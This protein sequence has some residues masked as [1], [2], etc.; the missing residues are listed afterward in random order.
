[1]TDQ[2]DLMPWP[3]EVAPI[4]DRFL[5]CEYASLSRHGT[6]ITYPITPYL[7]EVG[8][9]LDV[10]CG[11][12]SPAKAERARR[13]PDVALLYSE[14]TG[15]GLDAPPVVLVRGK[16]TVRDRDL[17]ANTDRYVRCQLAKYPD[18]WIGTPRWFMRRQDWYWARIWILVTP[19]RITWWPRGRMD[20][21]PEEW[22]ASAGTAA[23][24]SDPKPPGPQ[25]PQWREPDPAW[26]SKLARAVR[27]IGR[28]VLTVRDSVGCPVPFRVSAACGTED[29]RVLL[30]LPAG[31]PVEVTN[32]P[33]CLTFHRHEARFRAYENAVFVGRVELVGD[34]ATFAAERALPDISLR[35][36][37]EN[38]PGLPLI[39]TPRQG[40]RRD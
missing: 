10:S 20:R 13:N 4:F 39:T 25:P 14:P 19:L 16:A 26:P 22:V 6:P 2:T 8:A 34:Q 29:R 27:E 33:A 37:L 35:A 32:G 31:R 28:P 5:V 9:T 23:P 1:M 38:G 12:T 21:P 7:G 18:P 40:P 36:A 3:A 15:S 30:D 17:Q 24:P 11:L